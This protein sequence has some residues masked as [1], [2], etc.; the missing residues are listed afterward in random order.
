MLD[1]DVSK[2]SMNVLQ[3]RART[4]ARV[5]I[6]LGSTP[7]FACLVSTYFEIVS[8]CVVECA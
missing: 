5:W 4:M 3:V 7:V 2:T 8:L 1:L 6:A